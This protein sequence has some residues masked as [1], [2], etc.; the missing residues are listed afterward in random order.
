MKVI[1][2]IN[3]LESIAPKGLQE[4]YD[5]SGLNIGDANMP[6]KGILCTID[7]TEEVI[8]ECIN[9]GANLIIA[10]HP[11]IFSTI[12]S[13][14]GKNYIEKTIIKA[15]Q[16]NIAIYVGHTNFDNASAGVNAQICQKL[17]IKNCK[18]LS[19]LKEHL[20]KLSTYVPKDYTEKVRNALFDAGAGSI[21]NYDSCS[22][23]IEGVGSYRGLDNSEQFIGKKGELHFEEEHKIDVVFPKYIKNSLV[24]SLLK[25]HPYEEVAYDIYPLL[26]ENPH[27]GAGMIGE[28]ETEITLADLLDELKEKFEANG[29]RYTGEHSKNIKKVAVCGGSGS[30]LIHTAR[31][32]KA[33]V[34]ITGDLK[35][36]QFFDADNRFSLVD[37]GHFESE[38]FT[39]DLFYESVM[40]KM[41]KFAVH[42]SKVKTSPIKYFK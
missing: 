7:I 4:S 38:Q 28:L 25:V 14:T 24:S 34:F 31:A 36:H 15:I 19:P 9:L 35:Y 18:I 26:N 12:K 5:N 30:F 37:I 40:K 2:V 39:K 42:L 6:I 20:L 8:D 21:G 11:L 1:D 32:H 22:F 41:P 10:H 16:N 27:V 13:L 29:I 33:D 3:I 23:N 17:G